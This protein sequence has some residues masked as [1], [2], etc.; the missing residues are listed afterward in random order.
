MIVLKD[1]FGIQV[2]PRVEDDRAT[3]TGWTAHCALDADL[4]TSSK[5]WTEI[6][7]TLHITED[8]Q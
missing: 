3:V 7:H 5:F 1:K 2:L 4:R 8:K 6:A